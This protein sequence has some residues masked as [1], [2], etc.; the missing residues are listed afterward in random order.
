LSIFLQ[1]IKAS[2]PIVVALVKSKDCSKFI[3]P[4]YVLYGTVLEGQVAGCNIDVK[5]SQFAKTPC[6]ELFYKTKL[7]F[8]VIEGTF[9]QPLKVF[10]LIVETLL[11]SSG[12][13][14][15]LQL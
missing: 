9:L 4:L 10:D 8:K 15:E 6:V 3:Q 2:V 7:S 11:T 14:I 5:D 13:S 1:F 12:L